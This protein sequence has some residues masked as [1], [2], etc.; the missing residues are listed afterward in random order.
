MLWAGW[1]LCCLVAQLCLTLCD[2]MDCSTPGFPVHHPPELAQTHVHWVGDTIHHL[3]LCHPLLFLPSV[4]P[5]IRVFSNESALHIRWL[6]YWNL[7]FSI[8]PSNEDSGLISF[9]TNWFD[10]LQ[11]KGLSRV[12]VNTTGPKYQSYSNNIQVWCKNSH[13]T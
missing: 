9:R 6:R 10:S 8:S 4:F 11:S 3:I 1:W 12:F 7:S 5:S 13:H 2:P